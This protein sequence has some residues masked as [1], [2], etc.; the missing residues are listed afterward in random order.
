MAELPVRGVYDYFKVLER[1]TAPDGTNALESFL[2]ECDR[3]ELT[4]GVG[5]QLYEVGHRHFSELARVM[6]AGPD[7][8]ACPRPPRI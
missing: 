7:C 5:D 4:V 8:P 2:A 3:L 1:T 6:A